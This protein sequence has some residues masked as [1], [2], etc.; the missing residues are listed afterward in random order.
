MAIKMQKIKKTVIKAVIFGVMLVITFVV[1][2]SI[3]CDKFLTDSTKIVNGFFSEDKNSID[4]ICLGSSNC[5]CTIDPV[6]MYEEYGITAYDFGSSS[7]PMNLTYLYLQEAL[8]R[9]KPKVVAL[10]VN[11]MIGDSIANGSENSLR[12]G[13]TDIP[14]SLRKLKSLYENLGK[15]DEEYFSYVFPILRYHTRWKE[16]YKTDYVYFMKDK[17]DYDKGYNGTDE[18]SEQKVMLT[19]Y[20]CE[21]ESW[22][23]D[24]NIEYLDKITALCKKEGIELVLFKSPRADWYRY[25]TAAVEKLAN[26]RGLEFLDYNEIVNDNPEILGINAESDF[27]DSQHLNNSGADK[28]SKHFGAYLQERYG[29]EDK[30][31]DKQENS[32]DT[33]LKYRKRLE[34]QPF[35]N[36]ATAAECWEMLSKESDYTV[37]ITKN[38]VKPKQQWVY[39]DGALKM[40]KSWTE[41]GIEHITL[42]KS[43]LVLAKTAAYYQVMIDS[44]EYYKADKAWSIVVYDNFTQ[45]T[46]ASLTF[47]E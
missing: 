31:G 45:S 40:S 27:R 12:W 39:V 7:Q 10:E 30:R 5:F 32:W 6:V 36:S 19:A 22:I 24:S 13:Y 4:L 37:I 44:V 33:A 2:Q 21:G 38:S 15:I 16:L 9:Q 41:D 18:I 43:Q 11:M 26:E 23:A 42:G 14:L 34:Q 46:V 3:I 8:A 29:L 1:V 25:D 47:D 28:I 17:T 35:M 20:D